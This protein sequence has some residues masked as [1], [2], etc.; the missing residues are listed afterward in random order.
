MR[1]Y[2]IKNVINKRIL[3]IRDNSAELSE[4]SSMNDCVL[5]DVSV[6]QSPKSELLL[7]I[8]VHTMGCHI[9]HKQTKK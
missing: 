1:I 7:V 6:A 4:T 5:G 2:D 8:I 3:R 9:R